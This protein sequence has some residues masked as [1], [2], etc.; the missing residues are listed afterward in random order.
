MTNQTIKAWKA[1]TADKPLA[2]IQVDDALGVGVQTTVGI[3]GKPVAA[4]VFAPSVAA[5]VLINE[6][7]RQPKRQ[8]EGN[9]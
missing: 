6:D 3:N 7:A 1:L 2:D 5:S 8:G 9:G 4:L